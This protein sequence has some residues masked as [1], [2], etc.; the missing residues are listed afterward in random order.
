MGW[1]GKILG[2]GLGYMF[3]G[4]L[5]AV[6]GAAVGHGFDL[7]EHDESYGDRHAE[8]LDDQ[9]QAAFFT[10]MFSMLGKLAKA[11][12]VVSKQ[13]I[14]VVDNFM[15]SELGLN[16][17][18]RRLGI[19]I[20]EEAKNSNTSFSDFAEHFYQVV[21]GK[22]QVLNNMMDLLMRVAMADGVLDP[23]E[24]AMLKQAARIFNI[25]VQDFEEFKRS[26]GNDL[27]AC[28]A[29]LGASP[30]DSMEEIKHKYRKL[31]Q[32]YH[33]DVIMAKGLPE[34]FIKFANQKFQE[35]QD[36]YE[37]IRAARHG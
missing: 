5:G 37:K 24:E 26:R 17:E 16:E 22:P 31:A 11:D 28:Y 8:F 7:A 25:P 29:V 36:A 4:P 9:R 10:A 30:D 15:R 1:M 3:G 2:G 19:R 18:G 32:E 27:N 34:E 21:G 33:P 12:G 14:E 35:I 13:E 6:L 20:F 23:G